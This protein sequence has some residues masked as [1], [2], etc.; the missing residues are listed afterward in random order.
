MAQ[1]VAG[2]ETLSPERVRDELT[3]TLVRAGRPSVA[4]ELARELGAL[5]VVLPELDRCA[6]V[7]QNEY[8]RDDVFV[9]SVKSCDCAPRDNLAVR[10]AALLHDVGKVDARTTVRDQRGER[11]VFYG[12]ETVSASHTRS[13]LGRLRYPGAFIERCARLVGHHMFNYVPQWRD[14]TVRRFMRSVGEDVLDDLFALREAD[15][16]SRGLAEGIERVREL[17]QRVNGQRKARH[18][19][20]VADLAVDGRDVMEIRG[21]GP[22]PEVGEILEDLLEQ[23]IEHPE[24]NDGQRLREIIR[25]WNR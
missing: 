22:G 20:T 13:A 15:C 16:R 2:L 23:V 12:H 17:R 7:E 14:A 3:K 21:I 6:G 9:H 25:T 24:L 4:F 19:V 8:H 5:A 18:T 11:V 1:G 10:W